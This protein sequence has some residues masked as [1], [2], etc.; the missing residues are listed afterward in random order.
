MST[1]SKI[2]ETS[3]FKWMQVRE[4]ITQRWPHLNRDELVDCPNDEKQLVE[5]ISQR[6]DASDDEINSVV[7]E[8]APHETMVDRVS[9]VAGDQWSHASESAQLAYMRADECIASRPTESVLASF[10]AGILVGAAVTALYMQSTPEP[11]LWDRMKDR[12]WS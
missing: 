12:S 7:N 10:V 8:F 6:V 1:E 5:F 11:S 4:A 3:E 9:Q 2:E